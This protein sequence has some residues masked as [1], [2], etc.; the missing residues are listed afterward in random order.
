MIHP[1]T[2][3]VRARAG[4]TLIELLAVILIIGILAVFLLPQ[5]PAALNRANVTA[6]RKNLS[7][8]YEALMIHQQRHD[9]LPPGSG[10]QFV[11]APITRKVW[12]NTTQNAKRLTCPGVQ[13]SALQSLEGLKPEEWFAD[14]ARIDGQSTAYAGRNTKEFPL[15]R[16]GSGKEPLISDDNDGGK[17]HDTETLVL[18]SDGSVEVLNQVTL[19]EEGLLAEDEELVV[20]PDSPVEKLRKLSLD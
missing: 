4:F 9:G 17:N 15:R 2:F 5:I 16:F 20:G 10:A 14:A 12:E 8:I 1:P 3:A 6:C 11:V 19:T 7:S 13:T 18:Y